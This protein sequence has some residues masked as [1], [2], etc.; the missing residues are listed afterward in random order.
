MTTTN[1]IQDFVKKYYAHIITILL[2]VLLFKSCND[3]ELLLAE[4]ESLKKEIRDTKDKVDALIANNKVINRDIIR[5]K[6]TIVFLDEQ[7]RKKQA[8]I[9]EITKENNK[10][11][12][13][14]KKYNTDD[15]VRFYI[16]R[17]KAPREVFKTDLGLT[18]TDTLSKTIALDLNDYDYTQN[19]LTETELLFT[20]ERE[21]VVIQDSIISLKDN[22]HTNLN[23]ALKELG[24]VNNSQDDLIRK[25]SAIIN[26][27]TRKNRLNKYILPI[28][29]I[30]AFTS[31]FLIAK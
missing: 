24:K 18:F 3:T 10:L 15:L 8:K 31:G 28:A 1:D 19:L 2:V 9:A 29:V 14:I 16:E 30:T 5:Y 22:Q 27:E 25:Q 11:K 21:K 17:Y 7:T 26:K 4:K 13:S 23:N 12:S 6:D 20:I